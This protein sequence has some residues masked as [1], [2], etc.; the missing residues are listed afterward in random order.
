VTAA[1]SDGTGQTGHSDAAG[2][3]KLG[4][5]WGKLGKTGKNWGKLGKTGEN[6]G[7]QGKTG[8]FKQQNGD[9]TSGFTGLTTTKKQFQSG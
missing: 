8:G 1:W 2:G 7:K 4:K 3:G 5:N 6:R 9:F